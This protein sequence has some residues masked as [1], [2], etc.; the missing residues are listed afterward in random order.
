MLNSLLIW[1]ALLTGL[2]LLVV[3][4]RRGAGALVLAYFLVLSLGHIPGVLPY[5]EPNVYESKAAATKIGLDVT[6]IGM[7]AFMIGA[8][9]ARILPMRTTGPKAVQSTISHEAMS[10]ISRRVLTLGIASYFFFMPV[11]GLVP[12]LTS[13]GCDLHI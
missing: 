2:A 1:V 4:K 3:D 10:L 6:L 8:I 11:S 13:H 9:A 5:L 12:S 7:A